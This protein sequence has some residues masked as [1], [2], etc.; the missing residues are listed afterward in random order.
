[1]LAPTLNEERGISTRVVRLTKALQAMGCEVQAY[2]YQD[3][4]NPEEVNWRADHIH[5]IDPVSYFHSLDCSSDHCF[6]SRVS[7]L[8]SYS[9]QVTCSIDSVVRFATR[10]NFGIANI[11][12]GAKKV[13]VPNAMV[14]RQ[15][16][17]LIRD[18]VKIEVVSQGTD[19]HGLDKYSVLFERRLQFEMRSTDRMVLFAGRIDQH[20]QLDVFARVMQRVQAVRQQVKAIVLGPIVDVTYAGGILGKLKEAGVHYLGSVDRALMGMAYDRASLVWHPGQDIDISASILEAM[21]RRK[22][23]MAHQAA[24]T[25]DV[26]DA[27][28]MMTYVDELGAFDQILRLLDD[29][30]FAKSLGTAGQ[31]FVSHHRTP[32]VEA[33]KLIDAVAF[34]GVNAKMGG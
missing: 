31:E 19:P 3:K 14:G 12:L 15:I 16:S 6:R 24:A 22:P 21:S 5:I 29:E 26:Y 8:R 34:S 17:S 4:K 10:N 30:R 7:K 11:L 23:T 28:A 32:A 9:V 33:Q 27:Q 25:F 18:N 1:M 13:I 20:C 2:G